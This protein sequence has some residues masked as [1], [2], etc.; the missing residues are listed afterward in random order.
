[1][2][3]SPELKSKK[4]TYI[5]VCIKN[6]SVIVYNE[7]VYTRSVRLSDTDNETPKGQLE[8]LSRSPP[9]HNLQ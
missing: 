7:L 6:E 2:F 9:I 4:L 8:I 1:M 3:N 5:S